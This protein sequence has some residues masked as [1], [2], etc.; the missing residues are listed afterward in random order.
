[1][2][3]SKLLLTAAVA[4]L[5]C[6]NQPIEV[7]INE[8][9]DTPAVIATRRDF[10][11]LIPPGPY[12]IDEDFG[13]WYGVSMELYLRPTGTDPAAVYQIEFES[14][15]YGYL[16][17]AGD[18]LFPGDKITV[19]YALFRDYRLKVRFATP[20]EGRHQLTVTAVNGQEKRQ[21]QTNLIIP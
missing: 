13:R 15:A 8:Q 12:R 2:I 21:A 17:I 3:R 9:A 6:C 7:R 16:E 1:M 5:T 10:N 20:L 18:R 11:L 4:A 19:P 14:T